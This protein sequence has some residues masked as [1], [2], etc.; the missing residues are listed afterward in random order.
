MT[1]PPASAGGR[2][3]VSLPPRRRGRGKPKGAQKGTGVL[4]KTW[5]V[6]VGSGGEWVEPLT[7]S[8][9]D[10]VVYDAMGRRVGVIDRVTRER[11]DE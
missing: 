11:R 10:V 5:E 8:Y 4:T 2:P 3:A 7:P 9:S 1:P 6:W